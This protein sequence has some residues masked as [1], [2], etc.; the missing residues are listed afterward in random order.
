MNTISSAPSASQPPLAFRRSTL[1]YKPGLARNRWNLAF[2]GL[3]AVFSL[4][5]VL[6]LVLVLAYVLIKGGSL[7]SLQLLTS[8]PPAPGLEGGG[9]GNAILGTVVVILIVSFIAILVGVG[10]GIYLV[11]YFFL[12]FFV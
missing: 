10:G 2:T 5:A 12:G 8:L 7:I 11:K 3:A 1:A 4:I 6:P 9:I